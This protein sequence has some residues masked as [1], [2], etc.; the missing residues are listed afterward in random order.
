MRVRVGM[1][2]AVGSLT[3]VSPVT[4]VIGAAG[5]LANTVPPS[6]AG[7][8]E[9]GQTL[10][11][12][13]GSWSATGTLSYTYQWQSCDRFGQG[14]ANIEGATGASYAPVSEDAGHTLRV[15][16]TASVEEHSRSRASSVTQPMATAGAPVVEQ[17]PLIEGTA[18]AGSTLKATSGQWSGEEPIGYS[19]Q[20][21]RCT[22]AGECTAIEGAT[23]S[24]YVL[25]EGDVGSTLRL[26]VTATNGAGSSIAL[27]A[28]TARIDPEALERF[29]S[30]SISGVIEVGGEPEADPG[31]W[32]G[33]GPVSYAYQ[34][35]SCD[36]SGGECSPIEGATEAGYE[37]IEG[38]HGHTL[39]VKVTAT[40]PLGSES[41]YSAATVATP[42]GEVTVEQAEEAAQ[43][44]DPAILAPSTS[45]IREEQLVTPALSDEEELTSTQALTSS[46]VSKEEPGE[47][48]VNTPD[49][50]L[51]LKPLES[52]PKATTL[53]TLV[54]GTVALFANTSPATDTII[55]PDA[56]GATAV[57]NLRSAEAPKS[58]S[59][60]VGLGA[61]EQLQQLSDGSVAV[62]S[63]PEEP[64]GESEAEPS[65]EPEARET[66][67][68]EPESSAEKEEK[69]QEEAESETEAPNESP[70]SAP[71]SS[72]TPAE[73]PPGELEPQNTR[74]QYES[75]TSAMTAAEAQ[76]GT[77]ALMIIES[78]QVV[79]AHGHTVPASLSVYE[80]TI[81]M[82]I[83][84]DETTTYPLLVDMSVAAPSDTVSGERDPFGYGIG[85]EAEPKPGEPSDFASEK[86][87]RLQD[88]GSPLHIQ[89]ARDTVPWNLLNGRNSKE[90]TRLDKWLDSIEADHLTPYLTI[91]SDYRHEEPGV[92]Q[93]RTALRKI[94]NRYK[95]RVKR[96]GAWNEP[97]HPGFFYVEA[98]RAAHYWQAAKSVAVE[99]HCNCTIVAGEFAQYETDSQN[100]NRHA[101]RVYISKYREG[102]K[103]FPEAWEYNHDHKA[104]H[105]AWE[106]NKTPHVW[107]LHDYADVVNLRHT[108]LAEFE[109]FAKGKLR[110]PRIWVSEAGVELHDGG[111]P[112]RLVK[113]KDERYEYEQQTKAA[114]AFVGLRRTTALREK[115]SPIERVYYYYYEAPS[116]E[117]VETNANEFDS[118]LVEA[119][120]E[121]KG[122][123]RGEERPAYC[124]LAYKNHDCPPT[125][126]TLP[127]VTVKVK[128]GTIALEGASVNS[129]GLLTTVDFYDQEL[130]ETY[131]ASSSTIEA[132]KAI[133]PV[134]VTGEEIGSC[135]RFSYYAVASNAGGM[136]EGKPVDEFTECV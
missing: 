124:Y 28:A 131:K 121:N 23:A 89:T 103:Y 75:A 19:Y 87:K 99:L 129:H 65:K 67:E 86:L 136:A 24:S 45:I 53:P 36:S 73:V 59:W 90:V 108:N 56:L 76:F 34:W 37:F 8:P 71:T 114:E 7:T 44:T 48:A 16:V 116:E 77:A 57:L 60:E 101:N 127:A 69:E 92:P 125:V 74:T 15:Q 64:S 135:P 68:E 85:E 14:C 113:E 118:G 29:S 132:G 109:Q 6:V 115:I 4:P 52:S 88:A 31:I 81:T 105:H 95:G 110:N 51:G 55:R 26:L 98:K 100:T 104:D 17:A 62:I 123:S 25:A 91:R 46:S 130:G 96:W 3:D 102:L 106:R 33:S 119:K 134:T 2:S 1:S 9:V 43:T 10:T 54:N 112:T 80:N 94:L 35:E 61:G 5:A 84:P 32:S 13:N 63:T 11:A 128:E 70:P 111:K 38:D 93:Y 49:G 30:P 107:G 39:R 79:D 40:G 20:W 27:S 97:D 83:K 117:T 58:F 78:P 82:T 66:G 126:T 122:K 12:T 47:F 21:E 133:H 42:G 72:T 50:E 22:E 41:A 18:L 120:P